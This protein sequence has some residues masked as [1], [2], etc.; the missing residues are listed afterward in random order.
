MGFYFY[1]LVVIRER[2]QGKASLMQDLVT[3]L[4]K[5]ILRNKFLFCFG[6]TY[7]LVLRAWF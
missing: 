3:D 6:A 7:L 5:I 2:M 4:T 1:C